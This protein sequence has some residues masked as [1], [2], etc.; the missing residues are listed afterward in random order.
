MI[1][2]KFGSNSVVDMAE[3]VQTEMPFNSAEVLQ[4]NPAGQC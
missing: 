3:E 4:E 1:G 2:T